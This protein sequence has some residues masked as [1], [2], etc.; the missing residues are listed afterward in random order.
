MKMVLSSN[1]QFKN[2]G[3]IY[4]QTPVRIVICTGGFDPLHEGHIAY[5]SAAKRLGDILVVGINSD[6]WLVRKKGYIFQTYYTRRII[7][8]SLRFVDQVVDF[9]DDDDS[10]RSAIRAAMN[11]YGEGD[12]FEYL[13]ANGGDRT[14]ENIPE[15]DIEGINFVFGVG[16]Y[17]K[18]NSSSELVGNIRNG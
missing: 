9:T 6:K 10:S 5:L 3:G 14:H 1:T 8:S 16:G 12:D 7:L 15:M 13:F 18:L 11:W 4:Y 17:N 2:L